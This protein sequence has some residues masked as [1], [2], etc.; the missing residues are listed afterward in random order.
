MLAGAFH[1]EP[2]WATL[3]RCE[4]RR[5]RAALEVESARHCADA[6]LVAELGRLAL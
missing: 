6:R 2:D 5:V 4:Y 1:V 3:A